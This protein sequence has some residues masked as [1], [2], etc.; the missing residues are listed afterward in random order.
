MSK[1]LIKHWII[2][3]DMIDSAHQTGN[4]VKELNHITDLINDKFKSEILS[5]LTITLGDEFQGIAK[6]LNQSMK[7]LFEIEELIIK[8]SYNFKLRYV[9]HYGL[10]ESPINR[11]NAH[12]MYGEGLT[13]SREVISSKKKTKE[14]FQVLI[15]NSNL[16]TILNNQLFVI[17]ALI[18][19]WKNKD[20]KF[21][22]KFLETGDY[23]S[24]M[25]IKGYSNRSGAWKK[26]KSLD[27]ESYIRLKDS[28]LI[29]S[30]L[31][32]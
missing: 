21:V 6:G 3:A 18:D 14:R 31:Y 10:I 27:L 23:R 15:D 19:N 32:V 24:L 11:E 20:F 29:S 5:P 12:K 16:E 22:I 25:E 17:Q 9:L 1:S 7:I 4:V 26:V 2:M 30:Q 8:H 28:I 13:R